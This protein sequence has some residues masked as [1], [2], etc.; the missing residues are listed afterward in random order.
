ME[1]QDCLDTYHPLCHQPPVIDIDV[2]DPR[3]VWRCSK[4]TGISLGIFS[5]HS[6]EE[7]SSENN[8]KQHDEEIKIINKETFGELKS[9]RRSK[10]SSSL[11]IIDERGIKTK[12]TIKE[13]YSSL[14]IQLRKRIGSKLTVSRVNSKL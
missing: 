1:C 12:D 6:S 13:E 2:Y 7:N 4:C 9:L 8:Y 14:G 5:Q 11:G 3:L 10:T